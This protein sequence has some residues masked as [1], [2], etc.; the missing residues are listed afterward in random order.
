MTHLE[1]GPMPERV[2]YRRSP[3]GDYM[4][5]KYVPLVEEFCNSGEPSARIVDD[6]PANRLSNIVQNAISHSAAINKVGARIRG[7]QVWLTRR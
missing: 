3:E 4:Y 5:K 7:G 1:Y 2:G 6:M